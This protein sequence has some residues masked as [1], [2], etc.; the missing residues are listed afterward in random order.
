MR[1][2]IRHDFCLSIIV[3]LF[4][5]SLESSLSMSA[6]HVHLQMF[7]VCMAIVSK[8]FILSCFMICFS[9][10][11]TR[12]LYGVSIMEGHSFFW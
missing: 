11:P 5:N 8:L 1:N 4:Q 9:I 12:P 7:G 2:L 3:G 6:L 10:N